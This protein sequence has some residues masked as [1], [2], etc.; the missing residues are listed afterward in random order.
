M[1][2]GPGLGTLY[3]GLKESVGVLIGIHNPEGYKSNILNDFMKIL[4]KE[5]DMYMYIYLKVRR[6]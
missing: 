6:P 1:T 3:K 4:N 2:W 5:R